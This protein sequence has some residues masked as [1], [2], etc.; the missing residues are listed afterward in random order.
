MLWQV[1]NENSMSLA[2]NHDSQ[3]AKARVEPPARAGAAWL[4]FRT[5]PLLITAFGTLLLLSVGS[6]VMTLRRADELYRTLNEVN[7]AHRQME[8]SLARMRAS[9]HLS[10]LVVRDYLLDPS[11][12]RGEEY[13]QQ[14]RELKATSTNELQ[15]LR[16]VMDPESRTKLGQLE[17][18]TDAYW[19]TLDPVFE[20]NPEEKRA[21]SY[22]FLRQTVL[23]RRTAAL[24]LSRELEQIN[25]NRLSAQEQEIAQSESGFS[26][27]LLRTLGLTTLLGLIVAIASAVRLA[28]LEKRSALERLRAEQ[29]KERAED[30]ER[31]MRTLSQRLVKAQEEE[32]RAISRELHDEISQMLTGLRMELRALRA[33]HKAPEAE[34]QARLDGSRVV[35]EQ[36]VQSVRDLAMGLRP[37]ML[38]DLGLG[39]ALE[40]LVR[41][42]SRRYDIPVTLQMDAPVE[43]LSDAQSTSIFRITQE[44]LTNCARHARA[45]AVDVKLTASTGGLQLQIHDNGSGIRAPEQ[46]RTGLGLIGMQERARELGGNFR[47]VSTPG[48][49]TTIVVDL[50]VE[51]PMMSHE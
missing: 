49:G 44:A 31:Q 6:G 47:L 9:I 18:E 27:F 13:R 30:A 38:D 3:P 2:S 33:L 40:W 23:P 41:D 42:F 51:Q 48:A 19:D 29:Q 46:R 16:E 35:L 22:T 50:P 45:K 37:S 17:S 8:R 43:D 20:W 5:W 39:P 4:S 32:R 28:S 14:L 15:R 26:Y 1:D 25:A 12:Q 10:G 11:L 34:F 24:A 21:Q 7:S 36:T